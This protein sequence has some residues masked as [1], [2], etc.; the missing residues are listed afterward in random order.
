[1]YVASGTAGVSVTLVA[2]SDVAVDEVVADTTLDDGV[3][4]ATLDE[5][6]M[7]DTVLTGGREA[8]RSL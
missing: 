6:I 1:V 8:K 4:C 2:A 7:D 5:V 3:A